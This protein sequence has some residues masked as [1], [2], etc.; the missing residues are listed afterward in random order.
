LPSSADDR[1]RAAEER[2]RDTMLSI[3]RAFEDLDAQALDENFSHSDDLLAFGTDWDEKFAGW[4][5][6]KDVHAVQFQALRSFRFESREL[7]VHVDG[8]AA[9][10]ADR[11]RWRI[12]TKAGEKVKTEVRITAVLRWDAAARRWLVV[13]WHVSEGLRERLHEY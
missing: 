3:Y 7:E 10:A 1:K 6:Y 11:P 9:W 8:K 5:R 12:E 2:V 4:K 13:Q